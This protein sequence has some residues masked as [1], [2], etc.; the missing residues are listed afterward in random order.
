MCQFLLILIIFYVPASFAKN[1]EK[2]A[3]LKADP[4]IKISSFRT[5]ARWITIDQDKNRILIANGLEG[6]LTIANLAEPRIHHKV[7]VGD[8]TRVVVDDVDGKYFVGT[9]TGVTI[10]SAQNLQRIGFIPTMGG[11]CALAFDPASDRLYIGSSSR[12]KLLVIRGGSDRKL[13]TIALG[14]APGQMVFNPEKRL[15]FVSIPV[16]SRIDE[17]NLKTNH[18]TKY[19][20]SLL[21]NHPVR[22]ALKRRRNALIIGGPKGTVSELLLSTGKETRIGRFGTGNIGEFAQDALSDRLY[23]PA[24]EKLWSLT[25]DSKKN[26]WTTEKMPLPKPVYATAVDPKT[27]KLWIAYDIGKFGYIQAFE[28][29]FS[30]STAVH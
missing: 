9:A 1:I 11:V 30:R 29:R 7:R 14:G 8:S 2:A 16:L 6:T 25:I 27:H 4:A 10:V 17:I 23:F 13:S 24:S 3:F 18:L 21:V 20:S 28:P 15:M 19:W 22:L 12:S 5:N 26:E